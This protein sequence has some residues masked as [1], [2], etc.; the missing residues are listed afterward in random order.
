MVQILGYGYTKIT[1]GSTK[2]TKEYKFNMIERRSKP[3]RT[4]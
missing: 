1:E 3:R 2:K 4:N